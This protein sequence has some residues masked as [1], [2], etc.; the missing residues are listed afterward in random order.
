LQPFHFNFSNFCNH[1]WALG[2]CI[3]TGRILVLQGVAQ[4]QGSGSRNHDPT[5]TESWTMG[6]RKRRIESSTKM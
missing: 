5:A 1:G 3:G 2:E 6:I 4:S